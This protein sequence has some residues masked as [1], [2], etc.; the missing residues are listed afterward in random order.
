MASVRRSARVAQRRAHGRYP[1]QHQRD[2]SGAI[3]APLTRTIVDPS[4]PPQDGT[5][6]FMN[7]PP[8]LRLTIAEYLFQDRFTRLTSRQF[9]REGRPLPSANE[10]LTLLHVNHALRVET[11][12]L[13]VR[14]AEDASDAVERTPPGPWQSSLM[15]DRERL[16]WRIGDVL[17]FLRQ[18]RQSIAVD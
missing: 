15:K 16:R 17:V 11:I 13:C 3:A 5:C 1:I 2:P 8:E 7:L 18:T 12:K 9:D 4:V 14:F 6:H 10:L